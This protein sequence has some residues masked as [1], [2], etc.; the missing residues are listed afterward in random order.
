MPDT[1]LLGTDGSAHAQR[2][3]GHAIAVA[4][5]EGAALHAVFVVDTRDLGEPALSSIELLID[6]Y[7][8]RGWEI[9]KAVEAT[10]AEH[11]V[12]VETT[13]C[14]GEPVAEIRRLADEIDAD[15]IFLGERGERHRKLPGEVTRKLE[16]EDDRVVVAR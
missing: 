7:E 14:H 13:C 12:S 2:A 15:M 9:L 16:R 3:T 5:K 10:A 6:E 1:I 4:A 11:G 8:D